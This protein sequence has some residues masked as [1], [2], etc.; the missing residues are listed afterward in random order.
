MACT[1][2]N[3]FMFLSHIDVSLLLSPSLSLSLK[4][5]GMF[6]RLRCQPQTHRD[7]IKKASSKLDVIFENKNH[8]HW[9]PK[10]FLPSIISNGLLYQC[11]LQKHFASTVIS[12]KVQG[13]FEGWRSGEI[14]QENGSWRQVNLDSNQSSHDLS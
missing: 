11:W 14:T 7:Y 4:L 13:I 12:L 9:K 3:Q 2:G 8:H 10:P 5:I 6:K 1:G